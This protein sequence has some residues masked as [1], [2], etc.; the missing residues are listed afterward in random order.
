M[1]HLFMRIFFLPLLMVVMGNVGTL[2]QD[3]TWEATDPGNLSKGDVV[4]IVDQYDGVAMPNNNGTSAPPAKKVKL[5]SDKSRISSPVTDI[6]KW[7]VDI[8]EDGSFQFYA[9][10]T[11]WLYCTNA[12]NGVRVGTNLNNT[13]EIKNNFL[14][15]S[16][17]SRY[18]GVYISSGRPQDWR[19]YTNYTG[20]SNIKDTRIA[21]YRKVESSTPSTDATL[22][23]ILLSD[24]TTE[25]NVG[26]EFSFGGIVTATFDDGSTLPV[27]S[28]AEFT[29]YN[30]ST[31]GEQTVTVSYTDKGV[32]KTVTYTI[33]VK[34][35]NEDLYSVVTEVDGLKAGDEVII[36]NSEASKAISTTQN[37]NNRGVADVRFEGY[38]A[39]VPSNSNIQV[40]TLE[41]D[42]KGWY[43]N[44]GN[45]YI[46]AASSS[47]N[48]LR[49]EEEK[50]DNAKAI[51]SFSGHDATIEFQ[52]SNT[53]NL[54]KYNNTNTLF[55]CYSSGQKNVQIYRRV[56][57]NDVEV[58]ISAVG[59]S[60]LYYGDRALTVPEGVTATT[61]SVT[62]G[63]LT[64]SKKYDAGM[65]IPKGEAAVLKGAAGKYRFAAASTAEEVDVN[66]KLKGSDNAEET[67]GGTLYYALTLNK[68]NDPKSVGFYWMNE[69][70]TAFTNGAHKAYLAL[71]GSLGGGAQAKSSY[72]FS[73]ATTGINGAENVA[74]DAI[75]EGYNLNGQRVS[76]GYR[77]IVIV[78]GRKYIAK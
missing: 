14:Y 15:N 13:F 18:L 33:V 37:A 56:N 38:D 31:E 48:Y 64:E 75:Q 21:F 46:Y 41:G 32:T 8:T 69:T 27:T 72:L 34:P 23:S 39:I 53:R 45:G 77:G 1:K 19:C 26:D 60:T 24:Y 10:E 55:S 51:I 58:T 71:D 3:I 30:M 52:G 78:N 59:Y 20:D 63:K 9:S 25:F 22:E 35:S 36:V 11:T 54:L 42:A 73:E 6:L 49:T 43:F 68:Q 57:E 4:V 17:T 7:K 12:N 29:G 44:T 2:A 70:G 66:N 40:F 47:N 50:D 76:R 16:A 5:S 62:D 74:H 67:T 28:M 61:Y 65:T